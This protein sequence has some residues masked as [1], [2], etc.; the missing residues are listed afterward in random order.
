MNASDH[1][2]VLA[3]GIAPGLARPRRHR[4]RGLRTPYGTL[5]Y[6]LVRTAIGRR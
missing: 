2:L 4:G 3:A 6:S 1:A 5:G